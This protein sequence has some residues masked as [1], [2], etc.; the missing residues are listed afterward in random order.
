MLISHTCDQPVV[1]Q[2]HL[3]IIQIKHRVHT[4]LWHVTHR[5]AILIYWDGFCGSPLCSKLNFV[6]VFCQPNGCTAALIAGFDML[7]LPMNLG[8]F[9]VS[10]SCIILI[11][12]VFLL[13]G[14]TKEG[15][16]RTL[17]AKDHFSLFV[18]IF[19]DLWWCSS[20]LPE[21]GLHPSATS[22][23]LVLLFLVDLFCRKMNEM[24]ERFSHV[25]CPPD[26]LRVMAEL[27]VRLFVYTVCCNACQDM[28]HRTGSCFSLCP[29]VIAD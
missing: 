24:T 23:P 19:A 22:R 20:Q 28:A 27:L 9:Q 3:E 17:C 13:V 21:A 29:V 7:F 5:D 14:C 18:I 6:A 16:T 11:H 1:S 15:C 8:S 26:L 2:R 12:F 4:G 10:M 25:R